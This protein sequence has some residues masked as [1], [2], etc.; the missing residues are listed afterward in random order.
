MVFSPALQENEDPIP[1]PA[2]GLSSRSCCPPCRVQE[3]TTTLRVISPKEECEIEDHLIGAWQAQGRAGVNTSTL[4]GLESNMTSEARCIEPIVVL[5]REQLATLSLEVRG[6]CLLSMMRVVT[7]MPNATI[8]SCLRS[9]DFVSGEL[10][11]IFPLNQEDFNTLVSGELSAEV[12]P[13][14][15]SDVV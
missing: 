8:F 10:Q 6:Y 9:S 7:L 12:C 2:P 4:V 13:V 15:V 1:V 11:L 3:L 5:T 14:V